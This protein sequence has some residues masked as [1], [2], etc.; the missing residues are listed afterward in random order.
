MIFPEEVV[1]FQVLLVFLVRQHYIMLTK[2]F[3]LVVLTCECGI[4]KS[5][6]YISLFLD[7]F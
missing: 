6:Y 7:F 4:F 1:I 5:K 2:C 3:I